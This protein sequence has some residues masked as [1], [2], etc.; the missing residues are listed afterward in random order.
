[1]PHPDE[2]ALVAY[3]AEHTSA[4][5]LAVYDSTDPDAVEAALRAAAAEI[6]EIRHPDEP[7]DPLPNWCTVLDEDGVAVLHLDMKDEVAYA[8]LVVR[9]VLDQLAAAGVD[10]RLEPRREPTPAFPYDAQADVYTGMESLTELDGRGLPPGFPDGFPVPADATLV[11]AQRARDGGAEHA[12]WRS[13]TGPFTGYLR[14]LRDYGCAFGAVPRLLTVGGAP[15]MVRYALWRDGAGGGVA[16]FH[17][18]PS[19]VPGSVA[20]WY[21]S[22][23]WQPEAEPPAHP[24]EPDEAPDNRP[25]PTGPAAARE[26]AEFLVPEELVPGIE[27][28]MA[29]ATAARALDRLVS[30]PPDA[31]DRRRKPVVVA[32]RFAPVLGRLSAQQLAILRHSCLTMVGNLIASGRRPRPAGMTLVPDE[33]GHLYDADFREHAQGVLEPDVLSTFEAGTTLVQSGQMVGEA[34]TGIRGEPVRPPAHRYAWLFA[35]LDARQLTV[36]RDACWRILGA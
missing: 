3:V 23:V 1:M 35:G 25:V 14:R 29:M 13:S 19:R 27:A 4:T 30:A 15:G 31:A 32:S 21:A 17:S 34:V 12:A 11:L 28:V 26:L 5:A 8:A 22:V 24:V 2:P 18:S 20:Y 9:I 36:A 7:E 6:C 33:D 16:L 10:G